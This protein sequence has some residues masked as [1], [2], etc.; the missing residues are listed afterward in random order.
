MVEK[1]FGGAEK[2]L[3]GEKFS[4]NV[5]SPCFAMLELL[6]DYVGEMKSFQDLAHFL[7]ACSLKNMFSRHWVDNLIRPV[8]L[9]M[10]NV[11]AEH[12]GDFS[13]RLQACYKTMLYF[14]AAG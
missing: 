7:D 13:L 3:S 6:R 2:I 1:C 14:F 8:M 12:E 4:M 5:K 11:C 9:I 10:M